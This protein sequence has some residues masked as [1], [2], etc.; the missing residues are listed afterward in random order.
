MI[1][2]IIKKFIFMGM[3]STA[4]AMEQSEQFAQS[5]L[6]FLPAAM[7]QHIAK[8]IAHESPLKDAIHYIR[9]LACANKFFNRTMNNAQFT[10]DLI[11]ILGNRWFRSNYINTACALKTP[12]ALAWLAKSYSYQ[13]LERALEEKNSKFFRAL[14]KAGAHPDCYSNE[15]SI[16]ERVALEENKEFTQILL[17]AGAN[18]NPLSVSFR[19]PLIP[20]LKTFIHY[21]GKGLIPIV[22][23]LEEKQFKVQYTDCSSTMI[24]QMPLKILGA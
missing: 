6:A 21:G 17:D 16:L 13:A 15:F 3:V 24:Q 4:I 12:T 23:M 9:S 10:G 2:F 22:A 14:L 8:I 5:P 7:H 11:R 20:M 19:T 18:P 1:Y